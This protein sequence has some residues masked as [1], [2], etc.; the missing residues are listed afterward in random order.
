MKLRLIG[1]RN[2]LGLGTHFSNT[3]DALR[4]L[5]YV[6]EW[7]EE[8][9][10]FDQ[11]QFAQAARTSADTDVNIWFWPDQRISTM[12]GRHIVWAVFE[13]DRLPHDFRGFLNRHAHVVWVPTHWGRETL[14][15][16][17]VP[18]ERID[19]VPEGVD[20]DLFHGHVRRV[21]SRE[22]QPFRFLAVG[23]FERRKAYPELLE[24]FAQAFGDDRAVELLIKADYLQ[25]FERNGRIKQE[26]SELVA[27]FGLGN[28]HLHWGNWAKDRMAGLYNY[29]DAFVFPSRAEG[30]GLPALEAIATGM[31]IVATLY[32]GHT[33]FLAQVR[34]SLLEVEFTLQPIDDP[35]YFRLWPADDTNPGRWAQPSTASL[36]AGLRAVRER[37]PAYA[38]AAAINAS[39][40]R[41]RFSWHAAANRALES[42]IR[43]GLIRL[44]LK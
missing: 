24:A 7:I 30:W 33:E 29:C 25:D 41:E 3:A 28:V 22:G 23:K 32:S 34:D 5:L 1:Q 38:D 43:R 21:V 8:V 12:K 9:D 16:N 44:E 20:P 18:P 6:R 27:S 14:L 19:V 13:A 2:H 10:G 39:L 36:A 40:V 42:L 17:G 37:Y 15:A 4:R 35:E 26:L 31:P 11:S